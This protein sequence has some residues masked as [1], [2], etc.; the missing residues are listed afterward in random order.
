MYGVDYDALIVGG[1]FAG[2]AAAMPL[3][4]GRRKVLLVDS[5]IPRNRFAEASHGLF[6][7]D[8][9]TPEA[10]VEIGL[11]GLRRYPTFSYFKGWVQSVEGK[12]GAFVAQAEEETILAK[13]IVF[14]TGI[15]DQMPSI[16]GFAE[17]WGRS[18]IHCPYCHGYEVADRATAVLYTGSH[19]LHQARLLKEWSEDLTLLANG[20]SLSEEE[21]ESLHALGIAM[22][23][24]RVVR[25]D[26][27][28]SELRA[29]EFEDG[30][31][32]PAEVLYAGLPQRPS[33]DLPDR[34]GCAYI[35]GPLGPLLQIDSLQQTTVPGVFAAGDIARP[36]QNAT[37]AVADGT[38]AGVGAHRSLIFGT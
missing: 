12:A 34:L 3:L 10:I 14:A 17:R 32:H 25:L 15:V 24:S 28:G 20:H 27:P 23:E 21:K 30:G 4:R 35:E 19:S 29:V 11:D 6:G 38:L 16:E 33:S 9:R 26:G 2:M 8:G 5:G 22:R 18:V 13:R 1:S 36:M 7:L 37:F 31:H